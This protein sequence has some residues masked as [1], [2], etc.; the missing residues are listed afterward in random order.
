L[1]RLQK[2]GCVAR[3]T[4]SLPEARHGVSA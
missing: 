1:R 4:P 3:C 2:C